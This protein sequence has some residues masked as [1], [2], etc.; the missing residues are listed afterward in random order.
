MRSNLTEGSVLVICTPEIMEL[1]GTMENSGV[2]LSFL[3]EAH[4][5]L[6]KFA[7]EW[8]IGTIQK[9]RVNIHRDVHT[10]ESNEFYRCFYSKLNSPVD[11]TQDVSGNFA[12]AIF[13]NAY[14]FVGK[15][16]GKRYCE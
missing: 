7:L 10:E 3:I 8:E 11:L 14:G 9:L 13:P 4:K 1:P 16:E 15:L 2:K 12:G 5:C 6:E